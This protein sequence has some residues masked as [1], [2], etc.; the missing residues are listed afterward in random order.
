[1]INF[2]QLTG[3]TQEHLLPIE[4]TPYLLHKQAINDFYRLRDEAKNAGFN[5]WVVSTFRDFET[6]KKVWDE[7]AKGKR[8]LLDHTGEPM[9]YSSLEQEQI[10][11]A[12]L[13]WSAIPG[14]SRH[15]WGTDL[16]VI[17]KDAVPEG[18]HVELRPSEVQ[19]MFAPF[20]EW[21][22]KRIERNESFGFFRPYKDELGGVNPE[23]WH[24]SYAPV[25]VSFL[26]TYHLDTF[27]QNLETSD[28]ELKGHLLKRPDY[29][30]QQFFK[31]ICS[32]ILSE[33]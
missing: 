22:G 1:M 14:A 6:Q 8:A 32:P 30:Y 29:Y 7:K 10:L 13:R 16:D 11:M 3:R 21:L 25:S 17:D 24:L 12:I 9:D 5:L 31:N 2:E 19:G 23:A 26:E 20:Y 28:F 33:V 27:V 15:H 4:E 18:H